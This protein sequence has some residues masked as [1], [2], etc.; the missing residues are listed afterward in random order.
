MPTFRTATLQGDSVTIGERAD[1]G[2]QVLVVFTTTC[3][4]CRAS[5]PA[6]KR[7]TALADTMSSP[8]VEVL[9]VALDS[10]RA[11]IDR[12]AAEHTLPYR[13]VQ[14]P[15]PKLAALY[16]SQRVP[17]TMVLNGDGRVIFARVGVVDTQAAEDSIVEAIRW[18]GR[19]RTTEPS[20]DSLARAASQ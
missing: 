2:R 9:G 20:T 13:I 15:Q 16:R 5:L 4:Y 6:W 19:A 17:V 18:I 8:R 3:P 14:F 11:T 1:G 12:Y 7:L 10:S